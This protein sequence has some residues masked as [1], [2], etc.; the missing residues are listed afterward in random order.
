VAP[1][2]DFAL[3]EEGEQ[4][5]QPFM[6][7]SRQRHT[8][9][10]DSAE[11]AQLEALGESIDTITVSEVHPY[12]L[13]RAYAEGSWSPVL[14][15]QTYDW[16]GNYPAGSLRL[17]GEVHGFEAASPQ[18]DLPTQ[19]ASYN[20]RIDVAVPF[21]GPDAWPDLSSPVWGGREQEDYLRRLYL[22]R[23]EQLLSIDR[24]IGEVVDAAGP[25]TMII[26]TSDNGHFDGEHCLSNKLTPHEES[27]HV[28][29]YIKVPNRVGRP[30]RRIVANIDLAPTILHFAGRTWYDPRYNV[31]GRTLRWLIEFAGVAVWRRALLLEYHK[32]R[33]Q[34]YGSS[35]WRFGLPD[36]LGLRIALE[37]GG[38]NANSM[39]VQ[40]YTNVFNPKNTYAYERY[41][42]NVDPYQTD[43]VAVKKIMA[44]DSLIRQLYAASGQGFRDVE[45]MAIPL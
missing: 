8:L 23:Q 31:D 6:T 5:D 22:D 43:N 19:K 13:M 1:D 24:M 18:H 16:G 20:R 27:I 15:E 39:Y 3:V 26:F 10:A 40:Y 2:P 21:Y 30:V 9:G 45:N 37:A 14:P 32:P 33:G 35:D 17:N 11:A 34:N 44:L 28:P 25:N 42:M 7:F 41:L 4:L 36:Y 12:Y 38:S 29:L